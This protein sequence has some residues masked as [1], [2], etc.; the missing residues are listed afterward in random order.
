MKEQ[1]EIIKEIKDYIEKADE[2]HGIDEIMLR[3]SL[4]ESWFSNTLAWLLDPKANHGLGVRFSREFLRVVA[5]KRSSDDTYARRQAHLKFG[6]SGPG[7]TTA[8]LA[9]S[10]A[11]VLREFYLT[12]DISNKNS[13]GTRYCDLVFMDL[14]SDDSIFV[15]IE[16]KLF[17]RNSKYQLQECFEAI[18]DKY[19]RAKV[20]EYIYLT[21]DGQP[22]QGNDDDSKYF[23]YWVNI[24]WADDIKEILNTFLDD[25]S[26][27]DLC[28]LYNLLCYLS[29]MTHPNASM[30]RNINKLKRTLLSLAADCLH[31]ELD[32]LGE[33]KRGTWVVSSKTKAHNLLYHTSAPTRYLHIE[34]LP[35]FFI[36]VHG[37]RNKSQQYEKILIPFGAHP[38][39]VFSL[40]D[41]AARDIYHLH[42]EN[43]ELYLGNKRR[44]TRNVSEIRENN[45]QIL[46]F[47]FR[48]KY[49]LQVLFMI[50]A[51]I[52]AK[53]RKKNCRHEQ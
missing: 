50:S 35:N 42:F 7:V 21:L 47:V 44:L 15:V 14:G 38:D 40:L 26:S 45:L 43:T 25:E 2:L 22:P 9:M 13:R 31:E 37:K 17:T 3:R 10:N 11:T 20:R 23:K 29:Y 32:R 4:T 27:E 34:I 33:G 48:Y 52:W 19:F 16:N 5:Q 39:Q 51:S 12:S 41:I 46:N 1:K 53:S 49:E 6:K 18:E 24:S 28:D 36:T 30:F 8:G